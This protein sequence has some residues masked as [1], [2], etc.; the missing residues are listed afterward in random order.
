[1]KELIKQFI[2]ESGG[3]PLYP[4]RDEEDQTTAFTQEALVNFVTTIVLVC[5]NVA[6]DAS[7]H[8]A[9]ASTYSGLIKEHFGVE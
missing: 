2:E 7:D 5:A 9:P 1:M 8:R 3:F 6:K 4:G